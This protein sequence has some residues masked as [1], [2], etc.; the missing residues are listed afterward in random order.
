MDPFPQ[1]KDL[2]LKNLINNAPE[3]VNVAQLSLV[4]SGLFTLIKYVLV[5]KDNTLSGDL[6]IYTKINDL[7]EKFVINSDDILA[8][9]DDIFK[10]V[11]NR[12]SA[13]RFYKEYK[14]MM[15]FS[16]YERLDL[17]DF[18]KEYKMEG[19]VLFLHRP[20]F[21]KFIN[22]EPSEY[23]DKFK[24]IIQRIDPDIV[25]YYDDKQKMSY[26][27]E[28]TILYVD[29]AL[30]TMRETSKDKYN[31]GI[32]IKSINFDPFDKELLS[33]MSLLY[34]LDM[35]LNYYKI[36]ETFQSFV[37]KEVI[38][39]GGP[40]A[41]K[42]VALKRELTL[43]KKVYLPTNI[44]MSTSIEKEVQSFENISMSKLLKQYLNPTL[45]LLLLGD[46]QPASNSSIGNLGTTT[47]TKIGL[48]V[49][50]LMK[51][52]FNLRSNL[53][54][55]QSYLKINKIESLL[56]TIDY[57][58]ENNILTSKMQFYMQ[59]GGYTGNIFCTT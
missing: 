5:N 19:T 51:V 55:I 7:K 28:D 27:K 29:G 58:Y 47:K 1:I 2:Y 4:K 48:S 21:M 12:D 56:M 17:V 24:I 34:F 10:L 46:V 38:R 6:E 26:K 37:I 45:F 3:V 23:F 54:S 41:A 50:L 13:V 30:R 59:I 9:F 8:L 39:N 53:L 14:S 44:G 32:D 52:M 11:S 49:F 16:E 22:K 40:G 31:E 57:Y 15:L 20:L 25:V 43:Q 35:E 33:E 36:D 18:F 42:P